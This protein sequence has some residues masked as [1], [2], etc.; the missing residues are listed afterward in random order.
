MAY[1][2]RPDYIPQRNRQDT[3]ISLYAIMF[4]TIP[5]VQDAKFTRNKKINKKKNK[6]Y[7]N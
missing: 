1:V 7:Q 2:N 5:L 4:H 6:K 3:E